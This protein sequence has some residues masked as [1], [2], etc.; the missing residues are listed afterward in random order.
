[1]KKHKFIY[2]QNF[3]ILEESEA[4]KQ[5]IKVPNEVTVKL[6]QEIKISYIPLKRK[7]RSN[8]VPQKTKNRITIRSRSSTSE[9]IFKIQKEGHKEIFVRLFHSNIIH[10]SQKVEANQYP[11][12]DEWINT[13]GIH[14]QWN[15]IQP[16]KRRTL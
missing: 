12:T 2:I 1:M 8:A 14:I 10:N 16:Q 7:K 11:M 15:D 9:Y 4:K 6:Q 13:C 3:F 5:T